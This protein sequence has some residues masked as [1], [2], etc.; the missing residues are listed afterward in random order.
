MKKGR[1]EWISFY[2]I[3]RLYKAELIPFYLGG[4]QPLACYAVQKVVYLDMLSSMIKWYNF[5]EFHWLQI[6]IIS[7]LKNWRSFLK[8]KTLYSPFTLYP[9]LI[10]CKYL[11]KR[12]K[13]AF[14][15]NKIYVEILWVCSPAKIQNISPKEW[16]NKFYQISMKLHVRKSLYSL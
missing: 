7:T 14:N 3:L 4:W 13:N 10:F 9:M 1:L 8:C 16:G 6:T 2:F 5:Y 11:K 12:K 15:I